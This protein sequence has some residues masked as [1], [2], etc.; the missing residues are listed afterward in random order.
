M[1]FTWSQSALGTVKFKRDLGI[2]SEMVNSKHLMV[3]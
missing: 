2:K 1:Y 3:K